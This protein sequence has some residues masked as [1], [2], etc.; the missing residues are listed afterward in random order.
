M[1]LSDDVDA[2]ILCIEWPQ[3]QNPAINHLSYVDAL[4]YIVAG[5]VHKKHLIVG[6]RSSPLAA[7][8]VESTK[9]YYVY[10]KHPLSMGGEVKNGVQDVVDMELGEGEVVM[11]TR[12][13]GSSGQ[14]VVLIL[15][16]LRLIWHL[17]RTV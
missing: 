5:K 2:A 6:S 14:Q 1:A 13:V 3:G 16:Q 4:A 7:V 12:L 11:G 9:F 10:H 15:T 8:L 17:I